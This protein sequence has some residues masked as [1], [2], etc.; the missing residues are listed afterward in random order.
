[1]DDDYRHPLASDEALRLVEGHCRFISSR[2]P[3]GVVAGKTALVYLARLAEGCRR[4]VPDLYGSPT[5]T[6]VRAAEFGLLPDVPCGKVAGA[7]V[8]VLAGLSP[9]VE[10]RG[11]RS[12]TL[13]VTHLLDEEMQRELRRATPKSFQ[14]ATPFPQVVRAYSRSARKEALREF[15]ESRAA[16]EI[17]LQQEKA[18]RVDDRTEVQRLQGRLEGLTAVNS[19]LELYVGE[20]K[21]Y[22]HEMKSA[23]GSLGDAHESLRRQMIEAERRISYLVEE[24]GELKGWLAE[25]CRREAAA[26]ALKEAETGDEPPSKKVGR[27]ARCP[28]G[29]GRKYKRCCGS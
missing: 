10:S 29:S 21:G 9:V 1:M 24:N 4:G 23:L 2:L 3:H 27:N 17:E 5:Q 28:C 25:A 11:A 13:W 12:C 26:G 6:A 7:L 20:L 14:I 22:V 16:L 8:K 19:E 18:L 15:E